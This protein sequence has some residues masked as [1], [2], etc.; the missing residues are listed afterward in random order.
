MTHINSSNNN[1]SPSV[2]GAD[3][4]KESHRLK[5]GGISVRHSDE[6]RPTGR[7]RQRRRERVGGRGIW[8]EKCR[9]RGGRQ[10]LRLHQTSTQRRRERNLGRVV[11]FLVAIA[12]ASTINIVMFLVNSIIIRIVR[13][14]TVFTVVVVVVHTANL[15][16]HLCDEHGLGQLQHQL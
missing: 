13:I 5:S 3:R 15:R 11:D 14:V 10:E 7:Q 9:G 4:P 6:R 1:N 12:I 16:V 2:N 8:R